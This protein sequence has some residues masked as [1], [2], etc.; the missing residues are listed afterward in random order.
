MA[1]ISSAEDVAISYV[2]FSHWINRLWRRQRQVN[3]RRTIT[4]ANVKREARIAEFVK[5]LGD[6]LPNACTLL[7]MFSYV[8]QSSKLRLLM[9]KVAY[10][11]VLKA[12]G[13]WRRR[14]SWFYHH[15]HHDHH[16]HHHQDHHYH[17]YYYYY[18]IGITLFFRDHLLT[19]WYI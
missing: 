10:S 3:Q 18:T 16:H 7:L 12:T 6:V 2:T 19:G 5:H 14:F 11:L 4:A 13:Y 15:Y 17:H 1:G 9:G 8:C